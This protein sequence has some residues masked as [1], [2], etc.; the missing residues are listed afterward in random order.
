[1]SVYYQNVLDAIKHNVIT[2]QNPDLDKGF[3]TKIMVIITMDVHSREIVN[4]L[5][6]DR[7]KKP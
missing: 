7:I 3:R 5:I 4:G 1:M 2:V 6:E